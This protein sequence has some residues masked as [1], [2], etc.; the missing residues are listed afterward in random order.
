M[1]PPTGVPDGRKISFDMNYRLGTVRPRVVGDGRYRSAELHSAV[2]QIWNLR[3][4]GKS[5]A[6]RRLRRPADF[7]SPIR[8]SPFLRD[9]PRLPNAFLGPMHHQLEDAPMEITT[10]SERGSEMNGA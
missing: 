4:L 1:P 2:T 9:E 8:Q 10:D 5:E 6:S 3:G 7:K